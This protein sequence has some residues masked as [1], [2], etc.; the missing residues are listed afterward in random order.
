MTRTT[1]CA[2]PSSASTLAAQDGGALGDR[3]RMNYQPPGSAYA[4][5]GLRARV[6]KSGRRR[7]ILIAAALR[8]VIVENQRHV[9]GMPPACAF[10]ALW[11]TTPEFGAASREKI[12]V[13]LD[14]AEFVS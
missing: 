12:D 10:D 1:R 6:A 5:P 9:L 11:R 13:L 3:I 8:P 14:F 4:Q 7:S 2:S